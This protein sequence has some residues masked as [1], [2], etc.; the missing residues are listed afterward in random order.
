MSYSDLEAGLA[1]GSNEPLLH[2]IR[3]VTDHQ[4]LSNESMAARARKDARSRMLKLKEGISEWIVANQS[5]SSPPPNGR[6]GLCWLI[7]SVLAWQRAQS[8]EVTAKTC[9]RYCPTKTACRPIC[10]FVLT[11]WWSIQWNNTQNLK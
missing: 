1:E 2:S 7:H 9:D 10:L 5:V 4:V 6:G 8:L 3:K 11:V